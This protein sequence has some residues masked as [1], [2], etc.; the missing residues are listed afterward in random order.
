MNSTNK[1]CVEV[2]WI[3]CV[4]L[5][6]FGL[7]KNMTETKKR[8]SKRR[9]SEGGHWLISLGCERLYSI[10]MVA[11]AK[12]LPFYSSW[13]FLHTVVA[14]SKAEEIERRWKVY[15]R[16]TAVQMNKISGERRRKK[17][18]GVWR[19]SCSLYLTLGTRAQRINF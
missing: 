12:T 10:S 2:I 11:V 1:L 6:Y 4:A 14:Y 8:A 15:M 5:H 9:R 18:K 19:I 7:P 16:I 3:G 13:P 17:C